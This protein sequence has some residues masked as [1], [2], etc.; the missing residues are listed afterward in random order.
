MGV[1]ATP[2]LCYHSGITF[3]YAM[4]FNPMLKLPVPPYQEI[5]LAVTESEKAQL[6]HQ[7]AF[8]K[9]P[10]DGMRRSDVDSVATQWRDQVSRNGLL[11]QAD[12]FP[13]LSGDYL[14]LSLNA[15]RE[16]VKTSIMAAKDDAGRCEVF[17]ILHTESLARTVAGVCDRLVIARMSEDCYQEFNGVLVEQKRPIMHWLSVTIDGQYQVVKV[18]FYQENELVSVY[19]ES[20]WLV[21]PYPNGIWYLPADRP[22]VYLAETYAISKTAEVEEVAFEALLSEAVNRDISVDGT[23][24]EPN[25]MM[26]FPDYKVNLDGQDWVVEVTRV[27]GKIT[28]NRVI[29]LPERHE[30]S[31]MARAADQPGVTSEDVDAA[32]LKAIRDK[33][34]RRAFVASNEM[35]CLLL[36]DVMELIDQNDT[37]QWSKY[38]FTAFDSV[39]L[40]QIAP[41]QPDA[42][43]FI[44]GPIPSSDAIN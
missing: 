20:G 25:G 22:A 38:D 36:I 13:K 6:R 43:T 14:P 3:A 42:V 31:S 24:R 40:V 19:G 10:P 28:S 1:V 41:G 7:M 37:A 5:R 21:V 34:Q 26:T 12:Q 15:V 30:H 8:L 4:E 11:E 29:T 27:L 2:L 23:V 18:A 32:I 35:Y 33:S 39:V 9:S 16:K 17:Y 44:K